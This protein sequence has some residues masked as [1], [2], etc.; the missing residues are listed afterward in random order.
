MLTRRPSFQFYPG[1][2]LHAAELRA[3]SVG[4][5]GLCI[6]MLCLMHQGTPYGYLRIGD[7]DVP[8]DILAGMCGVSLEDC[9]RYLTELECWSVFSRD[10]RGSLFS[11]RMV[12]DEEIR[13]KRAAGGIVSLENPNVPRR[14]DILP[15]ESEASFGGS[16]SSSSSSSSSKDYKQSKKP[17]VKIA[18]NL[19]F[20]EWFDLYRKT[21]GRGTTKAEAFAEFE[22]LP[23]EESGQLRDLT[24]DWLKRVT[25]AQ[26]TGIFV[27]HCDPVR[28]IRRRRWEDTYGTPVG[29]QDNE[30]TPSSTNEGSEENT[31]RWKARV[32]GRA[33]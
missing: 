29:E 8:E 28:F 24:V 6:D 5:R 31:A 20:Q 27:A 9:Q 32:E 12:R 21:T 22:R 1:D 2:W 23:A 18:Y 19:P 16:P 7:K 26:L 15:K 30:P 10:E 13:L 25:V 11:R 3:C 14:K 17:R 4:A 33:V